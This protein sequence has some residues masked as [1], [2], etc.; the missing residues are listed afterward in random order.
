MQDSKRDTYVKNRLL[1]Y[2]GE[3]EDEM[4]WEN[5]IEICILPYVKEM[6]SASWMHEAGGGRKVRAGFWMGEHMRTHG[7]F[8][9]LYEKNTTI[10]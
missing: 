1:N 10:F 8:M 5:S 3:G 9:S 6:T 7:W 4:I 2:V